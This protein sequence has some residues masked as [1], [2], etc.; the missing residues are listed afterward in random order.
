MRRLI[1][2]AFLCG[3]NIVTTT[4]PFSSQA[5][6]RWAWAT[7]QPW[8][9]RWANETPGGTGRRFRRLPPKVRKKL[10]RL[11]TDHD[12]VQMKAA[13]ADD[14]AAIVWAVTTKAGERIAGQLCRD[15]NGQYV[16]CNSKQA[17]QES[18]DKLR[19]AARE[20]QRAKREEAKNQERRANQEKVAAESG[21][22][23][24]LA[25]SLIDFANP[26]EPQALSE[27]NAAA[28]RDAGLVEQNPDGSYRLSAAGRSYVTAARAG[29]LGRARDALGRGSE[30]ATRATERQARATERE[31][32]RQ[33]RAA[34]RERKRA[35]REAK[36]REP[37]PKKGGG[38][39]GGKG[40]EPQAT[41]APKPPVARTSGGGSGGSG[42]GS[43]RQRPGSA[44]D[45]LITAAADSRRQRQQ[46]EREQ[47]TAA[48]RER[49]S[50]ERQT[51]QAAR[52]AAQQQQSQARTAAASARER[53]AARRESAALDRL[54]TRAR[55]GDQLTQ[56][57]RDRL[58]AAGRA[59]ETPQGWR[60]TRTKTR[61]RHTY[62]RAYRQER[63]AGRSPISARAAARGAVRHR[64]LGRLERRRQALLGQLTPPFGTFS[65]YKTRDGRLRWIAFSSNG[66]LDNDGEYVSVKALAADVARTDRDGQYGPLRW[67][68]EGAPDPLNPDAPWGPG[69]DLGWCDFAAISGPCLVESGTFINDRIGM[70]IARKADRYAISLGFFHPVSEPDSGGVFHHIRRFER[71]LA[72]RDRVANPFT[73]FH[74]PTKEEPMNATKKAQLLG[75]LDT[76]QPDEVEQLIAKGV[77]RTQAA[78]K[79][80]GVAL[81][82]Q[83]TDAAAL[84][85]YQLPDGSLG[86]VQDGKIVALKALP[87][88]E[89][90]APP[91]AAAAAGMAADA[92][93]DAEALAEEAEA[94]AETSEDATEYAADLSLDQF[95][96]LLVETMRDAL[97][98]L[99][100]QMKMGEKMEGMLKMMGEEMKGY[101]AGVGK[102]ADEGQA[103][104]TAL[105]A[106]IA[107]LKA[108][109]ATLKGDTPRAIARA[110][111]A[112]A[113]TVAEVTPPETA[114]V[115]TKGG[116]PVYANAFDGLA[117]WIEGGESAAA[118]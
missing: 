2:A 68:H 26:D 91:E 44:S 47:A 54:E 81:K 69:V 109:I 78:A 18:K 32:K 5:Q 106:E 8:A 92:A 13:L 90:K 75:L 84:P 34:E 38:G 72:P 21:L 30:R 58:S 24:N 107:T 70:A 40:K 53:A 7:G 113:T 35:E 100:N 19:A 45:A 55:R 79:A 16:N 22:A 1:L 62:W 3:M 6:W 101:M 41:S 110:S 65:V 39:G 9:R 115:T 51:A 20:E 42:G 28:L 27:S 49:Q 82:T 57:D 10:Q 96:A 56:G 105:R 80:A 85:V 76:L 116:Q 4:K 66:Y 50:Q 99:V 77:Q 63:K 95:R 102:K 37:K 97:S 118:D 112:A 43:S 73:S 87:M 71:S 36:K 15:K 52:Q 94:E 23:Q 108:E 98:P 48:Q 33:E 103:D 61:R 93:A 88:A 31:A 25:E 117:G 111:R 59:E 60:L 17:T 89:E 104:V 14:G 64:D 29:D 74:V 67:W 11:A 46:Q 83:G 12:A 114:T 86:I